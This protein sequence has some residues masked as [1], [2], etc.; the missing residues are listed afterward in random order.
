ML[1]IKFLIT[2]LLIIS[3]LHND[4]NAGL[5]LLFPTTTAIPYS[6]FKIVPCATVWPLALIYT[7]GVP[8]GR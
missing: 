2:S 4:A 1:N 3:F 7:L 8:V 5:I 6:L